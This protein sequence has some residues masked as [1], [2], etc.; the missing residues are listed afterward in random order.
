MK[1]KIHYQELE[2]GDFKD[3]SSTSNSPIHPDNLFRKNSKANPYNPHSDESRS[4]CFMPDS[5]F[6]K[7]W[8]KFK[9]MA[10][11]PESASLMKDLKYALK[12]RRP[13]TRGFKMKLMH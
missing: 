12:G 6:A 10:K 3:Q 7:A 1:K 13:I 9:D 4:T 5:S 11:N 2:K 8:A